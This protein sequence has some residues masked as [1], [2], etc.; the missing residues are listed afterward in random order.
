MIFVCRFV[1]DSARL[2]IVPEDVPVR[3]ARVARRGDARAAGRLADARGASG[4]ATG[5]S[6]AMVF[7]RVESDVAASTPPTTSEPTNSFVSR[8]RRI[9]RLQPACLADGYCGQVGDEV[10]A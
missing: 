7:R 2:A 3:R 5:S 10:A 6:T 9:I 4:R 8:M 1:R